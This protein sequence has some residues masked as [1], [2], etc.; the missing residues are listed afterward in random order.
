[1]KALR[2]VQAVGAGALI[3]VA[4]GAAAQD[5]GL[6]VKSL[7]GSIGIIP[8]DKPPIEYRERPPLVVPQKLELRP[9]VDAGSVEA[10]VPNWPRDPDV[11]ARREDEEDARRPA[12]QSRADRGSRNNSTLTGEEIRAGTR[13]N[14][15]TP[16]VITEGNERN[17]ALSPAEMARMDRRKPAQ[18][19]STE[20]PE[21]RSLTEPPTGYRKPAAGA[22]TKA[23]ADPVEPDTSTADGFRRW[24]NGR[25]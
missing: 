20:E 19:V 10:R 17:S 2:I 12:G 15:R 14:A 21:R 24:V 1:M 4:S 22:P 9:P 11:L 16:F 6:A 25:R 5:E 13:A 8:K 7:L 3:L 18:L 23:S